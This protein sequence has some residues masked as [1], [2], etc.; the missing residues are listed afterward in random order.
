MVIL[1][2]SKTAA[3]PVYFAE[4]YCLHQTLQATLQSQWGWMI[5]SAC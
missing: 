2:D 4:L 1:D 3:I 5:D